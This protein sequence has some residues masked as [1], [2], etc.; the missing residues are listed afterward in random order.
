MPNGGGIGFEFM[1]KSL[2]HET[3][4]TSLNGD[5]IEHYPVAH[6]MNLSF[7]KLP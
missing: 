5:K 6:D 7:I 4:L 3:I 2:S 1:L